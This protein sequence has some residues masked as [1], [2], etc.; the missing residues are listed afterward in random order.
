MSISS[1][2]SLF[3]PLQEEDEEEA[4]DHFNAST[5]NNVAAAGA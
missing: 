5:W 1:R 3:S 4:V 2:L